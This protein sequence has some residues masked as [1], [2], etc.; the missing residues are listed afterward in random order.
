MSESERPAEAAPQAA[1][2][3]CT[4]LRRGLVMLYDLMPAI[5]IVFIAGFVALP[6]T[7]AGA[8]AG[9]NP[10][11][12]VYVL[13]AWFSYLG[14]CWTRSGQTLGMRAWRV[15]LVTVDGSPLT[16]GRS[17]LRFLA[18]L[19]SLSCLGLGF[20]I[21]LFRKDRACWHDLVSG[22]RLLRRPKHAKP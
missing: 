3:P 6:F 22:T 7:P 15:D 14:L 5:A 13:A 12:T 1:S 21:S 20:W 19:G 17:L 18:S 9:Y 11:Y 2:E 10:L 16:W 8:Q 4:L